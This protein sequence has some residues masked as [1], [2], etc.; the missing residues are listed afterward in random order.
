MRPLLFYLTPQLFLGLV[1]MVPPNLGMYHMHQIY[2]APYCLSPLTHCFQGHD[3][4][5]VAPLDIAQSCSYI[6]V[7][8][9]AAAA[10]TAFAAHGAAAVLLYAE[11]YA[12]SQVA[13]D[14]VPHAFA[15]CRYMDLTLAEWSM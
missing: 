4:C 1:N 13:N 15:C 11:S 3:S 12:H 9:A 7:E 8:E 2:I 14:C 5:R 6:A 10:T